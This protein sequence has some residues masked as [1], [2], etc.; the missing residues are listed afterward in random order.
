MQYEHEDAIRVTTRRARIVKVDDKKSQQRVDVTGLKE[1]K[2]QKI[3]RPQDFGFSSNPPKDCDGVMIQMGSRSDRTLYMDGGHEK[4]RPKKTPVGGAVLFNHTGD[5]IRVFK[6]NL[7]VVHQKKVNVR[8]GH[9][10]AAGESGDAGGEGGQG[11][12][13]DG[14]D[15]PDDESGKDEKTISI[16]MDGDNIVITFEQAKI[17]WNEDSLTSEFDD[18]SVKLE[19]GKITVTAPTVVVDSP[20]IHLGGEGGEPIGLCGGGC[21]ITTKAI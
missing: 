12:E 5:I 6:D 2:P 21:S 3:W 16:V 15:A 13:G 9:G 18:T 17:T 11:G 14:G 4:Y 7:D 20:D 19:S 10:Y 1:E 8:I